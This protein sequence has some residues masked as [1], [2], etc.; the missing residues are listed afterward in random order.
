MAQTDRS[1]PACRTPLPDEAQFCMHC[2]RATPTDPGV[3]PRTMPTGE[4]E[5]SKVRRVLA[6]RYRVER[7]I[8]EGGMATVYLAEDLKHKR[9]VAVKVMRPELAATLGSDRF[10]REVEIAANLSHPHILPMYDSGEAEG[11]LYY[12]MPYVEGES[13]AARLKREG[14]LPVPEA[15]RIAREVA[16]ALAYAHKRSI[17][18]RDIK[19]ANIL[20]GEGHA[21]VADFGIARALEAESEAITR[22]GLAIGTPQYMS[23]EQATGAKD[24]DART[25]LYAL[26]AVLYEMLAGEPPFTGRSPQAVVA[27]ALTE[28]PRPLASARQGLPAGL[29]AVVTRALAK[30]P[31]DRQA[32][33]AIM[34]EE[35]AGV[36]HT[37]RSG[38]HAAVGQSGSRTVGRSEGAGGGAVWVG[39]GAIALLVLV[40]VAFFAGRWGLPAWSLWLA[41]G[42]GVVGAVMLWLTRA[43][44]ARRRVG[45]S[46]RRYDSWLT[47]RN[48]AL[49]GIAALV[50][51]SGT[52]G[53]AAARRPATA[54]RAEAGTR[55]AVLPFQNLGD[56][57]DAYFADGIAD[58]VRGKL[59]RV[60]GLTVTAST[61][62]GQ[63]RETT[64]SPQEIARELGVDYLLVG[65]VRWAGGEGSRRVQVTPEVI[66][67]RT[68]A[69]TW[70]QAYDADLTD[71]FQVQG[72]IA[73]R[74]AAAI[75]LALGRSEQQALAERPTANLAA[76]DAYLKGQA[77]VGND[78]AS[79]RQAAE[80]FEQAVRLDST[81]VKAW[82]RLSRTLSILYN[83][84]TPSPELASRAMAAAERALALA[85]DAP[86]GHVSRATYY[87]VVG[88]NPLLAHEEIQAALRLAPNDAALLPQAGSVATSLGRW[89][90]GLAH[91]RQAW[92]LDPR[93]VRTA[94]GLQTTLLWMRRYREALEMSEAALALAPGDLSITQDRAMVYVAQG[95]L[96]GARGA[97]RQVSP[98]VSPAELAAFFGNYWDMYWV[99][100]EPQ[101]QLLLTLGPEAF[102]GD[103]SAWA[104]VLAEMAW[105]R[106]DSAT[107]RRHA[108][109]GVTEIDRIL[110][111]VPDDPQRLAFK[112]LMLAYLGRRADAIAAGR[113]AV[114]LVPIARDG[115]NG[116]YL[117][118]VLART[119][120]ALGEHDRALDALEPLLKVPYFLSP[121]WLR[122]DPTW[123]PLRGNPRFERLVAGR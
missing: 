40:A 62:T 42:L 35:L 91:Y 47:W 19:P 74:V 112:G 31:V 56:A 105:T 8:G 32:T 57:A 121:G 85:P 59:S 38:A 54:A 81:F 37:A 15:L 86:D 88:K 48:A 44:E 11:V 103:R 23:P 94:S 46:A 117:Q 66:D 99:L 75:G 90:E 72:D 1:C 49:G 96:A 6:D 100:E 115:A 110:G 79:L 41:G 68:G 61:S 26:G 3:P 14:E 53:I 30:R 20:L 13:L 78:P 76:Y 63:Y 82:A 33:A 21:L 71:V 64:K 104:I 24:V 12:V 116:P 97:I 83:N 60:N 34:A 107:A 39:A 7:V 95:D 29:E 89:D 80:Y 50:V 108:D 93:S 123:D 65:R 106:G 28:S 111:N 70:Q 120:V 51:W 101:Q 102:D 17:I 77:V 113:R 52:S 67:A 25:D 4:F 36:E 87:L 69:V 43:A 18:H 92:R 109:I 45:V 9:K 27:R 119:Y 73:T 58:E 16:D 122:V 55:L 84:G 98:T 118:H 5:V 22:T 2:G 10:L 114:E